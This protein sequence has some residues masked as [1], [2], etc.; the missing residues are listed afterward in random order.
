MASARS[1]PARASCP[2][3]RGAYC[4]AHLQRLRCLRRAGEQPGEA[5]W[6]LTEPPVPRSGQVS[7]AGLNPAVV[8]EILFGLQQRTR[9]GVRTH[10]AI[11][12]SVS[13]DARSQQVASL[14]AWRSRP[15]A[16]KATRAWCTR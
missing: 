12:R 14:A 4:D 11:L 2:P 13:N 6:R 7:L 5:A 3:P 10:D 1:R 16:G 9:Q 8:T 15:G